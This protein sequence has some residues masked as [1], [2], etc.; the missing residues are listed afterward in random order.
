VEEVV[1][2][3]SLSLASPRD[4]PAEDSQKIFSSRDLTAAKGDLGFQ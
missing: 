2:V 1:F 4:L 3:Q